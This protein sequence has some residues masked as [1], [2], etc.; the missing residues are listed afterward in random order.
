MKPTSDY[1]EI[2]FEIVNYISF[3][4]D[5]GVVGT[6]QMM[7]GQGGLYELAEEWSDEF[8]ELHK[9]REWNGE[10]YDVIEEF[11]NNKNQLYS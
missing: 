8:Y 9:D 6:T 2:H 11:C 5:D 7:E 1:L 3:K 4:I 10:F